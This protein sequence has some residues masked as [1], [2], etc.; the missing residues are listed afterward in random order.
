MSSSPKVTGGADEF[1]RNYGVPLDPAYPNMP[2][3][4]DGKRSLVARA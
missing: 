3:G 4:V 1:Q 2:Y